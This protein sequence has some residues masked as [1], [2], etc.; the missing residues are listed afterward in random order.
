MKR[1]GP[2]LVILFGA[3]L[4][5]GGLSSSPVS[6][7]AGPP[8]CD[9]VAP[10]AIAAVVIDTLPPCDPCAPITVTGAA[11]TTL[12]P[13]NPCDTVPLQPGVVD[14]CEVTTTSSTTIPATTIP[15]TTIAPTT[16]ALSGSGANLPATGSSGISVTLVMGV[17]LMTLGVVLL[18]VRRRSS[19]APVA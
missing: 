9:T 14:P 13:C 7:G 15:A 17:A 18:L 19:S 11:E 12:P 6:V 5:F 3:V 10:V 16:S 4:A 8:P 1:L 2:I